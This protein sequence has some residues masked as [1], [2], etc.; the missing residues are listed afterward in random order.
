M[1][2]TMPTC[3]RPLSVPRN[4]LLCV[5]LLSVTVVCGLG[6][7]KFSRG[8]PE[9]VAE[10]AGDCLWTVAV[11]LAI[12]ILFPSWSPFRVLAISIGLSFFVEISQ[13]IDWHYLD[14]VRQTRV[15]RLL[16]GSGFLWVDLVRYCVGGSVAFAMD[17]PFARSRG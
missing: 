17:Q 8:L 2:Y 15:G 16:L 6:S 13:L 7:R 10:N 3:L 12:C 1:L 9:F 14:R 5:F 4:R 11:Y